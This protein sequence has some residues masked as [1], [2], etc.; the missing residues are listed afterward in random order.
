MSTNVGAFVRLRQMPTCL[1]LT[2]R[3]MNILR[4]RSDPCL[5]RMWATELHPQRCYFWR[6]CHSY[7]QTWIPYTQ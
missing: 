1:A 3:R 2:L 7:L 6:K 5:T 4:R